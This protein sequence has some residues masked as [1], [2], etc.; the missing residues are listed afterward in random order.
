MSPGG[1]LRV[2]KN[3]CARR[4]P[5][6]TAT[7][8]RI[9][10]GEDVPTLTDDYVEHEYLM[11]GTAHTYRGPAT[12]PIEVTNTTRAYTTRLLVR[13]PRDD[14]AFS[15]RVLVEPF[16]TSLGSDTDALWCRTGEAMQ[17]QGDAWI[18][19]TDHA[20]S[21]EDLKKADPR[22]YAEI[23]IAANDVAW[24]I[25]THLGELLRS[26][27][28]D[29]PL[30]GLP[31]R[32]LYLGGYSQSGTETATY[33]MAFGSTTGVYD[34]YF[35][36]AH[37]A[38]LAPIASGR[39]WI[40]TMET[41]PIGPCPFPM[42]DVEPQG[43]VEGFRARLSATVDY[44]NPGG[45]WVRRADADHS[46]DHYRLY[47]ISGAPHVVSM[48]GCEGHSDFPTSAFVRAALARLY[49]WVE[50]GVSPPAAPRIA[51]APLDQISRARTDEFG[52][53]LAGVRSPYV[54]TPLARY[55]VHSQPGILCQLVGRETVLPIATLRR[56]Y[57]NVAGYLAQ[58]TR[59]LDGAIADGTLLAEDRAELITTHTA[60][61]S[62]AFA[63]HSS[64]GG[65]GQCP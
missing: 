38:S 1:D 25:L 13:R 43:D 32:W 40:L 64:R 5:A 44:L 11:S 20:V 45:A 12:G 35:P 46:G 34:G 36:A 15:G 18:G 53:A 14:G 8:A 50:D 54:D 10:D 30:H 56:R 19:V 7:I 41:A 60:K 48:P 33:A 37:A 42:V 47:E 59:G 27:A 4:H 51:L 28:V 3:E 39:D 29:N 24:D 52:N 2:R 23:D 57:G 62:L 55:E 49:R 9:C 16:N 63:T 58:F 21:D 6:S 22:R 26:D 31:I 65:I 17:R 61:A